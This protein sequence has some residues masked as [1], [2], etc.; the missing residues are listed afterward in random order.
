MLVFALF[1]AIALPR[2]EHPRGPRPDLAATFAAF[3]RAFSTY[4]QQEKVV[5]VLLFILTYKIGDEILFSLNSAFLMR[6]LGVTKG[7]LSW[8]A[9]VVAAGTTIVGA[10]GGSW[11]I[12]RQ[13]LRKAIWPM[14]IIM[15]FNIWAYVWLAWAKPDPNTTGGF[16]MIAFV[17][18]YENLAAALGNAVLLVYLLTTCKPEYKAAHYAIGAAVMSVPSRVVGGLGG[19]LAA[20]IGFLNFFILGFLVS[21]PSMLLLFVVPFKDDPQPGA[22]TAAGGGH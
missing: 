2:P 9:G 4:L 3:G 21:L 6:E 13:G 12:K 16:A 7:Q 1:H 5:L 19:A 14:T 18:G 20:H 17:H 22:A 8:L 10:M 15:N 11:W